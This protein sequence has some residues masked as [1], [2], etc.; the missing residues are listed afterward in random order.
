MSASFEQ[1]NQHRGLLFAI[2][3]RMLGSVVDAEDMVQETFLR[4]QKSE[5]VRSSKDYLTAIVTRLCI[6]HLRSAR[7]QREQ[8]I[9][10]WLPEPIVTST[11]SDPAHIVELADSLSTAFLVLLET[12]SPTERAIFLLREVFDYNYSEIGQIVDKTPANCRQIFKRARQHLATRKPDFDSQKQQHQLTEKFLQAWNTGDL[13]ALLMLLAQDIT[14]YSDGGGKVTAAVKPIHKAAKVARFLLAIRRS[15]KV[16]SFVCQ[17]AQINYQSGI[18]TYVDGYVHSI[19]TF[20][21][22]DGKIQSIYAVVN[23][24]KLSKVGE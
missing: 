16:S 19:L 23:P 3:Y 5:Q 6:D 22:F 8:Y 1:F 9:G 18:I 10:T 20:D 24:D 7:V 13:Q 12:L 11:L 14:L 2:A 21:V 17:L 4:W 15:K